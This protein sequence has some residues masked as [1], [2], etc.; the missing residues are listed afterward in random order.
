MEY[1][2]KY[3][4]DRMEA[5]NELLSFV[6]IIRLGAIFVTIVNVLF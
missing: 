2:F 1:R 6:K 3:C 4:F 5:S